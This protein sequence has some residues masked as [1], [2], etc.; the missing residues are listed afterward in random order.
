MILK[1]DKLSS[2][3]EGPHLV[4]PYDTAVFTVFYGPTDILQAMF[5]PK[6]GWYWEGPNAQDVTDIHG[7][8]RTS[9]LAYLDAK[10]ELLPP[11]VVPRKPYSSY[12][13]RHLPSIH[14]EFDL[15]S[16]VHWYADILLVRLSD[17]SMM[18]SGGEV[19]CTRY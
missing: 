14:G 1:P 7:P 9:C 17:G 16:G 5:L 15:A 2:S 12:N 11:V 13:P 19:I 10:G 6:E 8:F 3:H 4:K 18:L